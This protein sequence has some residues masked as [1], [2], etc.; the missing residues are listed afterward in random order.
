MGYPSEFDYQ[1]YFA[2]PQPTMQN[3]RPQR[4]QKFEIIHVMGRN[5]AEALQMAPD[6]NVLLLDDTAPLV[7]LCQTDGAGYKTVT[8][9]TIVPYQ[10]PTPVS[11]DELNARLVR[12]E[13][14]LSAKSDTEPVK[15]TAKRKGDP[16]SICDT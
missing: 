15:P 6:S 14:M 12:L 8:P 5:G 13:E 16:T 7:W 1:P 2:Y 10:E 11:M 3:M 9:Y 4:A